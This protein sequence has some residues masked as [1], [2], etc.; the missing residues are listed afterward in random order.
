MEGCLLLA[1]LHKY[2]LEIKYTLITALL[3]GV[4]GGLAVLNVF[5]GVEQ[6]VNKSMHTLAKWGLAGMFI[7]GLVSN[8]TLVIIVPY[9]LP[10]F[11]LVIYADSLAEVIALGAATGLGG[12]IGE[13]TS[14]AV[15]HTI[16]SHVDDLSES[17]LFRWTKRTIEK[18]PRLIPAFVWLASATVI[19][20]AA[21]IVPLA[22][23]KYP[24][25][26]MIFPMI[27]GKIIQNVLV[28][29]AFRYAANSVEGLIST[30]VNFDMTAILIVMFV[31]IIAYQVE[32]ARNGNNKQRPPADGM[33]RTYTN[34]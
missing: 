25:K 29:L 19:P 4:F 24:W 22:M 13:V 5:D 11:S 33:Q 30:D 16:V 3:L 15:A 27:T 1:L 9:N 17:A 32:K 20:D 6:G 26:K 8:M 12:G 2:R 34:T 10:M 14:Y 21:I 31:I 23:I 7:I 28:A 18:R